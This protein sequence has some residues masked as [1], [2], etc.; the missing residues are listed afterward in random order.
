M[1]SQVVE[2]AVKLASLDGEFRLTAANWSGS[3]S[4]AAGSEGWQVSVLNGNPELVGPRD[5]AE[6]VRPSQSHILISGDP[7]AWEAFLA[8]T[9]RPPYTDLFGAAYY[10]GMS[11]VPI[12]DE[13]A[14]HNAIRRFGDLLRHAHNGASGAPRP[15]AKK[16]RH[17]QFDKATG[18]Y[19]HLDLDGLDHRIYFEEA[20]DGIGLL[21]QHTAGSD[22]RQWRHLLE[23]ERV[24]GR[25]R[26]VAYDLPYHGKSLPPEGRAWWA[27]EYKL[28]TAS[29][30]AVPVTLSQALGLNRP[31]FIGSS[32][33]GMLGLDLARY[34]PDDFR[35]VVALE[36]GL[37][38]ALPESPGAEER[39]MRTRSAERLTD[40]ARHAARMHMVMAPT[41]SEVYRHETMLHYAQGAPGVFAGDI[42]YYSVDHD[43]RGQG[44]FID[45]TKCPVYLLTGEYDYQTVPVTEEAAK[46]IPG[47][48]MKI[49]KGL[50]HFPM[51]EDYDQLMRYVLPILEEILTL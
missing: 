16:I 34:H 39:A 13:A 48:Y 45:T 14:R 17:G 5:A 15:L 51:S 19:V 33:G 26:V 40:P 18:R 36:G 22:G 29:A 38:S 41:A 21:C 11:M 44:A 31:V 37:H 8:A 42:N 43:L 24:A 2:D 3:L 6:L 30:M 9:P 23:D 32:I 1:E 7:V 4:M 28:T 27:E 35:A 10:G 49:M 50:G 12:P 47:A 25:Y 20:G 46:E